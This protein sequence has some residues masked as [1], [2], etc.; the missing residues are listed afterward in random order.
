MGHLVSLWNTEAL[1]CLD[2]GELTIQADAIQANRRLREA[3]TILDGPR[4]QESRVA[5]QNEY[6]W[7]YLSICLSFH[8]IW[9]SL[10]LSGIS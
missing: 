10:I 1:Y 3:M 8:P 5:V 9:S 2:D 6:W 4:A 7:V